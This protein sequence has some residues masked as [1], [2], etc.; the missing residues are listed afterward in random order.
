MFNKDI[1]LMFFFADQSVFIEF[2]E[3]CLYFAGVHGIQQDWGQ[4]PQAGVL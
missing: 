3:S 4:E 1:K 2:L